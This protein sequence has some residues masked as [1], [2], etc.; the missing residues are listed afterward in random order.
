MSAFSHTNEL[1]IQ[2][3]VL[4]LCFLIKHCF[5]WRRPR[6]GISR[7]K[8]NEYSAKLDYYK[9]DW[10]LWGDTVPVWPLWLRSWP[11]SDHISDSASQGRFS[12]PKNALLYIYIHIELLLLLFLIENN[13]VLL[14][15]VLILILVLLIVLVLLLYLFHSV[16]EVRC[17]SSLELLS[18]L[19]STGCRLCVNKRGFPS[20]HERSLLCV[21]CGY[22]QVQA[23]YYQ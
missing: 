8:C 14:V 5:I 21:V 3:L 7:V 6:R 13:D 18:S 17:M 19:H 20:W 4:L 10:L 11:E 16:T 2:K 12:R 1:Q 22:V 23:A 9:I 15:L